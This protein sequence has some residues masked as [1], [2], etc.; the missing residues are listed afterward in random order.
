NVLL[1]A[2]GFT[3]SLT[4]LAPAAIN[5]QSTLGLTGLS[6][7]VGNGNNTYTVSSTPNTGNLT[8]LNTGTGTDT[9]NVQPTIGPLTV[10]SQGTDVINVGNPAPGLGLAGPLPATG[11]GA[12]PKALNNTT[13]P[14]P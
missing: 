4:G 12:G 7:S 11:Q 1:T 8:T 6:I 2:A 10:T 14:T 13:Q 3:A 5:F 9:V